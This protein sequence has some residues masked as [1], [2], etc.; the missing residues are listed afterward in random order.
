MAD[1]H[2]RTV[3]ANGASGTKSSSTRTMLMLGF[4]FIGITD[5]FY[6]A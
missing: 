4:A 3:K 5:A 2:L 6:V 1:L